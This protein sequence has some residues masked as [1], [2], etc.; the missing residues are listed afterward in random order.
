MYRV[1]LLTYLP[2]IR[3]DE[4]GISGGMQ[5]A[6][7]LASIRAAA[8][9]RDA[10]GIGGS[11][12]GVGRRGEGVAKAASSKYENIIYGGRRDE[13]SF[14]VRSRYTAVKRNR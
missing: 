7:V 9:L 13:S 3:G 10:D 12:P 2:R 5:D 1:G 11:T 14:I 6:C 4:N 8:K